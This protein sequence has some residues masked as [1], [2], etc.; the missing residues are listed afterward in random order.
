M[1]LTSVKKVTSGTMLPVGQ[2]E[3]VVTADRVNASAVYSR[4]GDA[5]GTVDRLLIDKV[6]GKIAYAVIAIGADGRD[7][8]RRQPLPWCVLTYDPLMGGYF[9]NL[10]RGVLENGPT[11]RRD[12]A[13]DWNSESFNRRLHDYYSVP[14][15]WI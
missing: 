8:D 10:D 9:V 15:F 13:V 3:R 11:F 5:L 4:A 2:L 12:E 7:G 6:S 1:Q 14:H